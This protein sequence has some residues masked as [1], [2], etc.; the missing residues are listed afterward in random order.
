MGRYEPLLEQHVASHFDTDLVCFTDDGDASSATWEIRH[1]EPWLPS[2]PARSSRR[3]KILAHEY[4]AEYDESIYIDNSVLLTADPER[5][6]EELL[7]AGCGMAV[8]AHSFRGA[9]REE[10]EAVTAYR[11]DAPW[12]CGEQLTHYEADDAAALEQQTLWGGLLVRRHNH[13]AVRRAMVLWWEHVL[14]FSR[15]DQLSLPFAL[16]ATG[17]RV[18]V[19]PMDNRLS[20]LHEWPRG[21][22]AHARDVS[23]LPAGP[24]SVIAALERRATELE[25]LAAELASRAADLEACRDRA[26]AER[27]GAAAQAAALRAST[28]WRLTRPLRAVKRVALRAGI[29]RAPQVSPPEGV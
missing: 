2:D 4:L 28:C 13:P 1:V 23:P 26:T 27:E 22:A 10:F 14:R 25:S 16:R 12:V 5:I 19:R 9:L 11:R 20:E 24:E 29:S 8:L 17:L 7:P 21:A 15:R 18:A 3:P 6:F